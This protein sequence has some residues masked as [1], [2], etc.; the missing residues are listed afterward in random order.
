MT[1][2][3]LYFDVADGKPK[4]TTWE[5]VMQAAERIRVFFSAIRERFVERDGLANVIMYALLLREH[6]LVSGPPGTA[7]TALTDAV[8]QGIKGAR[9]WRCDMSRFMSESHVF[10][11]FDVKRAQTEGVLVHRTEGSLLD[12]HVA[13]LGEFLDTN[14]AL[15]RSLLRVLN[16]REFIRG[17]Q[18]LN[19]P[20]MTALANTNTP[21]HEVQSEK[22][23][24]EAVLDRFLF[25]I[26]VEPVK[27]P[28]NRLRMLNM[29]L[30]RKQSE[31]L[32]PLELKDVV[33]VSGVILCMNL[34]KDAYLIQAYEEL[35]RVFGEERKRPVTDRRFNKGVQTLEASALLAGRVE[36]TWDDLPQTGLV[37]IESPEDKDHFAKALQTVSGKWRDEAQKAKT[38]AELAAVDSFRPRIP[39]QDPVQVPAT[40]LV[41]LKRELMRLRRE[42]DAFA[43]TTPAASGRKAEILAAIDKQHE[44]VDLCINKIE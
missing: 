23:Q 29:F 25:W 26:S 24:L 38:D 32:P 31:P 37:F 13:V 1:E 18:R 16:E 12:A 36:A 6:V 5:E 28:A 20:L 9:Q 4:E 39:T 27:E 2:P 10:G 7:K 34:V 35:V 42:V 8:V 30:E 44:S 41:V 33:M 21:P 40:E 11:D 15:L 17:P 14:D 19:I 22:P 43:V 3:V